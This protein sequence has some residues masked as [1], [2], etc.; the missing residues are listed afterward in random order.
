MASAAAGQTPK[1]FSHQLHLKLPAKLTCVTCHSSVQSS[2]RLEDNNLPPVAICLGC[3]KEA[4]ISPPAPRILAR[5][6]HRKHLAMGNV[7]PLIR[8]AIDKKPYLSPPAPIRRH[9]HN[10]NTATA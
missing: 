4:A 8:G 3:H 1:P 6:D 10:D 7:A 5:F 9:P 2:T